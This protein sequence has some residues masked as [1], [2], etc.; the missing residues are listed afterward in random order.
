MGRD[1]QAT[2]ADGLSP[3]RAAKELSARNQTVLS[4]LEAQGGRASLVELARDVAARRQNHSPEEVPPAA[5]RRT[6]N[7]LVTCS[8][9]ELTGQGLIE[10]CEETGTVW[11]S[12]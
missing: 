9:D 1:S 6:Y 5:T 2:S 12:E 7:E 3:S 8:L 4:C 10:V 11:L